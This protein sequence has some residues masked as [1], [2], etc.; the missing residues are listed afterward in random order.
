MLTDNDKYRQEML[1]DIKEHQQQMD[2]QQM[3]EKQVKKNGVS[4]EDIVQ[5]LKELKKPAMA[6]LKKEPESYKS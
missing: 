6:S 1:K 4:R 5:K 3:S 2:N